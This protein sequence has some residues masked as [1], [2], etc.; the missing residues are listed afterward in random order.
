ML[1]QSA[2]AIP[3]SELKREI[4]NLAC[5]RDDV[6]AALDLLLQGF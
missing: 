6:V 4:T 2:A 5:R 1:T 3:L